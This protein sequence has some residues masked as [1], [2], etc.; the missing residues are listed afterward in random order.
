MARMTIMQSAII[1]QCL[2]L[3]VSALGA[4][5]AQGQPTPVTS[6]THARQVQSGVV[7]SPLSDRQVELIDK[8]S[9]YFNRMSSLEGEFMQTSVGRA[10]QRGKFYVQRPG[11]FRF[12]YAR[13]SRLVIISD[14]RQVAI[15]DH[16]LKSDDRWA[17]ERTPFAVL[18]GR[19]VNLLRDASILDVQEKSDA[20]VISFD[21]K[22]GQSSGPLTMHLSTRPALEL[23]KWTTKDLQGNDTEIELR[24]IP[25]TADFEPGFFKPLPIDLDRWRR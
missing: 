25:R 2:W 14:G 12:D 17:L 6:G 15:Q 21:Q 5:K 13:P 9:A 10:R 4:A 3:A 7:A 16:D 20:I 1:M 11:R 23:K 24:T 19:D 18:L 8:V 22:G